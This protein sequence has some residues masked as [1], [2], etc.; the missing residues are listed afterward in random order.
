MGL[1]E[2]ASKVRLNVSTYKGTKIERRVA[3]EVADLHDVKGKS[4]T[5]KANLFPGCDDEIKALNQAE[6]A[7][8]D[9]HYDTTFE[10]QR[11]VRLLPSEYFLKYQ[12]RMGVLRGIYEQ[13]ADTLLNVWDERVEQAMLNRG[14]LANRGDYPSKERVSATVRVNISPLEDP[15]DWRLKVG[16]EAVQKAVDAATIAAS[17]EA[18]AEQ[19]KLLTEG[20]T[21][22]WER[23]GKVLENAKR[24]LQ[25]TKGT[26]RYRDEWVENLSQFLEVV[27]GLNLTDDPKLKDLAEKTRKVMDEIDPEAIEDDGEREGERE[28]ASEQVESI[29]DQMSALFTP[30]E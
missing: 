30:D 13:R 10:W 1:R 2:R 22:V 28:K 20:M 27:D 29:F 17:A 15:N 25:V 6:S 26:G 3:Q 7:I 11:G 12:E 19:D 8:R 16:D 14:T 18:R 23:F 5:F 24:N 21:K 4:G 9:F